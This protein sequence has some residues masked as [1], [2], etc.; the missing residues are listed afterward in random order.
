MKYDYFNNLQRLMCSNLCDFLLSIFS[1]SEKKVYR[2]A[3]GLIF[4]TNRI[5]TNLSVFYLRAYVR[6]FQCIAI[7]YRVQERDEE[8]IHFIVALVKIPML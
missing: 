1:L 4:L 2:S 7:M 5:F 3:F 6:L 8:T